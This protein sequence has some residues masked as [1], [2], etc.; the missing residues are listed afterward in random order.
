MQHNVDFC[1]GPCGP[2]GRP[3]MDGKPGIPGPAGE[4][5]SKGFQGEQGKQILPVFSLKGCCAESQPFCRCPAR[6]QGFFVLLGLEP[7]P[8]CKHLFGSQKMENQWNM[9]PTSSLGVCTP[10]CQPKA[11]LRCSNSR[12]HKV[13]SGE[14]LT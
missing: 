10:E 6:V 11:Q 13:L 1:L 8:G 7:K 5:G 9:L 2:K 3:G 14:P 12:S 4:K